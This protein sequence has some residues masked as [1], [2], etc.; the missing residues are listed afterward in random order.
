M[1][2]KVVCEIFKHKEWPIYVAAS[3]HINLFGFNM[4]QLGQDIRILIII[5]LQASTAK[6]IFIR[7]HSRNEELFRCGFRN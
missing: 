7:S 4:M 5:L 2:N 6:M 3:M 1:S